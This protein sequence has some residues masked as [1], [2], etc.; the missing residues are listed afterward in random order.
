MRLDSRLAV[1]TDSELGIWKPLPID[2]VVELFR[3]AAFRWWISGGKALELHLG[4]S[5]RDHEDT[6]VGVCRADLATVPD[7]LEGWDLQI[8]SRGKLIFFDRSIPQRHQ[9]H[10][11]LWCRPTESAEWQLDITIDEGDT[12]NWIYRRDPAIRLPWE[13]A[14]LSTTAGVPYLAPELQLLFKSKSVRTKDQTDAEHVIPRLDKIRVLRL[15]S[16]LPSSH[17]WQALTG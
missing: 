16:L 13:D 4:H 1:L 17:P 10:N 3:A 12:S 6:D 7:L 11:N 9:Q 14:V 8:A 2:A 15:S 5:W